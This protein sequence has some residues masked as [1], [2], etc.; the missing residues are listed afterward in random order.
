MLRGS[1]A[2]YHVVIVTSAK[3]GDSAMPTLQM[4]KL[5]SQGWY[6]AQHAKSCD[7]RPPMWAKVRVRAA[8]FQIQFP[9]N[10]PGKAIEE[11]PECLGLCHPMGDPDEARGPWLGP[12]PAPA[13]CGHFEK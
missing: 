13:C 3:V 11:G 4:Q 9:P 12:G 10:V 8:P 2:L 1:Q 7:C 6:V 5:R